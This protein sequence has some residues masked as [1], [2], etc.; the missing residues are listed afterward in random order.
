MTL[1]TTGIDHLNL[2][3]RSLD[4]SCRFWE[5]LLGFKILENIPEQN[6]KIIG[7][8][9]AFLALYEDPNFSFTDKTG[10]NHLSFHIENF[11]DAEAL[12]SK[13]G[14]EI[15]YGGIIE[16]EK[17]RSIYI[18]DPNGYEVELSEVWGGGLV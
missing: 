13:M 3:V 9:R 2:T 4:E 16:W 15:G 7:N 18:N 11:E 12:C 10:F 8:G 17:S 6:G 5:D 14:I 1:K